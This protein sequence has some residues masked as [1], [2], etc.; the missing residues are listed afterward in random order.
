MNPGRFSVADNPTIVECCLMP[1]VYNAT[2]WGID[3][4]EFTTITSIANQCS[5]IDGF[6]RA[7]P[8]SAIV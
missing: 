1:L 4:S 6:V 8:Q 3:L 5:E 2:R 7:Y